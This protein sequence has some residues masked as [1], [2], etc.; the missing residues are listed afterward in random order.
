MSTNTAQ[1]TGLA[2]SVLVLRPRS[3]FVE[4]DAVRSLTKRG[5]GFLRAGFPLHLRGP[6]G[7]GKTTLAMHVAAQLGRPVTMISGDNQLDT[8]DLVGSH[9]GYNYR[10]VVD[11]FI[12]TV[13]KLEETS[14]QHWSDNRLTT[15]CREGHTLVY[16][17]YTRSRPETHNVL[18]GVFEE[19]VLILP[20]QQRG[21]TYI[22]VHPDFRAILTSNP[23]EY[24][25]VHSSQDALSDRLATIDVDYPDR[26]MEVAIAVART[27][28][29]RHDGLLVVDLVRAFR[30]SGFHE[31]TPTMRASLMIAR[32]MAAAGMRPS[33]DDPDF[34]QLCFDVLA[35]RA[36]GG[37]R[38]EA[39]ERAKQHEFLRSLIATICPRPL[40]A[41]RAVIPN[42]KREVPSTA[43]V[44]DVLQ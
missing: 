43:G 16:D 10:K 9:R 32:V 35:A 39:L 36:S 24:A 2:H 17:E 20:A 34:V 21:E 4:T 22:R 12:H 19:K 29:A 8:S 40:R 33:I 28:V 11:K 15:A 30:D 7:T 41:R 42:A 14:E 26:E 3:D 25:G 6:A 1:L 5:L 27:G 13:T 37:K 31:Q 38:L 18:L 44:E 23:Q